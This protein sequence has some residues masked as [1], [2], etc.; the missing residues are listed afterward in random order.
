MV[1]S[2]GEASRDGHGG[3]T[4]RKHADPNLSG[5]S[6]PSAAPEATTAPSAL[7]TFDRSVLDG[8]LRGVALV[9][10]W[11][12][13]VDDWVRALYAVAAADAPTT[14]VALVAIGGYGRNQLC[15]GSDLDLLLLHAKAI[16][17]DPLAQALWY[18][19]WDS[20]LK[21][22]HSVR[23]TREALNLASDDLDTATSLLDVRLLAGDA[24]LAE[25][26]AREAAAQ[27]EKRGRRWLGRLADSVDERHGAAG[28]VA[29]LLEPDLKQGRGGLRDVHAVHWAAPGPPGAAG[30]RPHRV[31][32]RRARPARGAGRAPPH[33]RPGRATS[34][35]STSRTRWPTPSA[36]T[37]GATA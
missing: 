34:S 29:F 6:S 32:R 19:I 22:G 15:P 33:H 3:E 18:P 21:L 1:E 20:G 12:A 17:V 28:E 10:A 13:A 37:A 30:G 25:G 9:Q 23:T 7:P 36:S 2:S 31:R 35:P 14:G 11:T 16:D 5:V 24:R 8:P 26:L 4:D 27:W